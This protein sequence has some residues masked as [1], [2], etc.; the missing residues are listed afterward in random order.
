MLPGLRSNQRRLAHYQFIFRT[1]TFYDSAAK[2]QFAVVCNQILPGCRRPLRRV[3]TGAPTLGTGRLQQTGSRHHAITGHRAQALTG[4]R[5][6]ARDPVH[7][8]G[9]DTVCVQ[10]R[11]VVTLY[12]DEHIASSILAG[13][14][15]GCSAAVARSADAQAL[16]LT[17]RVVREPGVAT[18]NPT[19]R[20]FD[21]TGL[22]RQ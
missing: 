21:R 3:K 22:L 1:G 8:P 5:R 17:E 12:D 4:N 6:R 9:F 15:P 16:A 7:R 20:R 18:D 2:A 10:T 19:F 13:D 11:I 14:K